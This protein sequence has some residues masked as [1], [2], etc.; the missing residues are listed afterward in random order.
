MLNHDS[1]ENFLI[2]PVALSRI[3][4]RDG[5]SKEIAD[6]IMKINE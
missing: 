4:P 3:T 6:V 2:S 1:I 5:L